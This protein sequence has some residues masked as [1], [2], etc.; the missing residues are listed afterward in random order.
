MSAN[1]VMKCISNRAHTH[2]SLNKAEKYSEF[3]VIALMHAGGKGS[4]RNTKW[5]KGRQRASCVNSLC[6]VTETSPHLKYEGFY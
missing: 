5:A 3:S 2:Y 6:L 1:K 4:M